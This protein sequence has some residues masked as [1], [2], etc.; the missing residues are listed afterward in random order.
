[1]DW[2]TIVIKLIEN[3][4]SIL[5]A[6]SLVVAILIKREVTTLKEHVNSKMDKLLDVNSKLANLEGQNTERLSAENKLIKPD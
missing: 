4:G 1:M 2:N 5:T 3:L 6:F